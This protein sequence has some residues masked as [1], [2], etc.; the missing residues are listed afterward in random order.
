MNHEEIKEKTARKLKKRY[1]D[2]FS[3]DA[4]KNRSE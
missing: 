2:G 3:S 1:P 4:S